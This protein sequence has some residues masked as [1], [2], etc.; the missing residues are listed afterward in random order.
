MLHDWRAKW[1]CN[2]FAAKC[3]VCDL[4]DTLRAMSTQ[5][6]YYESVRLQTL[7]PPIPCKTNKAL[8]RLSAAAAAPSAEQQST[9]AAE[10]TAAT[11]PL[12]VALTPLSTPAG[13]L[14]APAGV[15]NESLV[16]ALWA[17]DR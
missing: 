6:C 17:L 9:D 11:V 4:H 13:Q 1:S 2:L 7:R 14:T 8:H 15:K 10:P 5:Q 3:P 12:L 16:S